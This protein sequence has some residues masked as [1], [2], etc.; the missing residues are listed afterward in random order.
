MSQQ[1]VIATLSRLRLTVAVLKDSLSVRTADAFLPLKFAISS[2][3]AGI[4]QMKFQTFV[5][6]SHLNAHYR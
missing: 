4:T 6:V 5:K 1:E 3:T 2:L